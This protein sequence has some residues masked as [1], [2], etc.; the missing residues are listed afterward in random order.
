MVLTEQFL[1]F[2]EKNSFWYFS[3]S[4]GVNNY[5]T[6][7]GLPVVTVLRWVIYSI[8]F[9]DHPGSGIQQM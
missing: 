9:K 8:I 3:H 6:L 7:V 1:S 5:V 2:I 4:T